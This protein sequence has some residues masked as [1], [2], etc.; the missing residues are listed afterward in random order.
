ML[1][2][3]ARLTLLYAEALGLA[4]AGLAG[5][6]EPELYRHATE[7]LLG[8]LR[9]SLW[10]DE[11]PAFAGSQDADESYYE[12]GAEARRALP[13]PAL[14]RTVYVDW[15]ALAVRALLRAS[16]V[17]QR[18]EL[19]QQGL[20]TLTYLW[21]TRRDGLLA[22]FVPPSG[23]PAQ[24]SPLF[25]DQA[26][27]SAALLDAYETTG[28]RRWLEHAEELVA[29]AAEFASADGR[30]HDRLQRPGDSVGLLTRPVPSLEEN[31]VFVDALLRLASFTGDER[32]RDRALDVLAAWLPFYQR[33]GVGAAPYGAALLRAG[34][35]HEHVAV[36][37]GRG[38]D[39]ARRLQAAALAAP[40]PL[41]TVQLLDP[42][43]PADARH[44]A[45]A[46]YDGLGHA[47][48]YVCHGRTCRAPVDDPAELSGLLATG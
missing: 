10:L 39:A 9:H 28:E 40:R 19:A 29:A 48:A 23:Q 25:T 36:V 7:G 22:H 32:H 35:L 34:E 18:P 38:D 42:G 13:A 8:H 45:A 4:Q 17:L 11:P 6:G 33:Y 12:L 44:I 24:G 2:D 15:N 26:A 30:Y 46:G 37:G 31:A 21:Q 5:L 3:E 16:A 27:V 1:E 41:R 43:D 14:D 47:A 20:A